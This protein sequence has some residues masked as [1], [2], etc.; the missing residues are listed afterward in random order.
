M[1]KVQFVNGEYYHIF[2]RGVDKRD[3]FTNQKDLNRFLQGMQEF[4]VLEP[5][6]SMYAASFRKKSLLRNLVSK[7]EGQLVNFI[8]Y[9]LNPN[10]YHFVLQQLV[11]RGIEKL[12]HR[13]G[14]GHSNYFNKKY[15]R[16]GS[17]FQGPFKAIHVDSD[18][19]LLHVSVY[20]NL[21]SKVHQIDSPLV[22]SSWKEY[23]SN[24]RD[25]LCAKDVILN[26][27]ESINSYKE[28]AERSL[29]ISIERKELE[30]HLET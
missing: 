21:N 23:I 25:G 12:M 28:F 14:I 1:R 7:R 11:D 22:K 15:K 19:H 27:F 26:Q 4:N 16:V 17:L 29:R 8:C 24:Y 13:L 18:E 6:G 2:N 10:H 3:I 20:V 30:K 5:I 9:C